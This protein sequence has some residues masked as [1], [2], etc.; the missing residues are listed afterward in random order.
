MKSTTCAIRGS[1]FGGQ[2]LGVATTPAS[3]PSAAS[4]EPSMKRNE[5]NKV[6]LL[7]QR[8]RVVAKKDG[9]ALGPDLSD[10]AHGALADVRMTMFFATQKYFWKL[11]L[12]KGMLPC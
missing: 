6:S 2:P 12:L 3:A 7:Y 4:A 10:Q 1:V 8:A 5:K 11:R 9:Q